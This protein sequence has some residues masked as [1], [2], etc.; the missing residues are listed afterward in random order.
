LAGNLT[1]GRLVLVV[2][3]GLPRED[4]LGPVGRQLDVVVLL[5]GEDVGVVTALGQ[6]E[7][8]LSEQYDAAQLKVQSLQEQVSLAAQQVAAAEASSTRTG[9]VLPCSTTAS[10]AEGSATTSS[11][12]PHAGQDGPVSS[13][14]PA[15]RSSPSASGTV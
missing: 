15:A 10:T 3:G 7:E 14:G 4:R 13:R 11:P 2:P 8:A 6:Q 5:H 9:R 1:G 12:G